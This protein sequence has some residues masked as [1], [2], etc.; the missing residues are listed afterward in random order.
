MWGSRA[1]C[2]ASSR[3]S[4]KRGQEASPHSSPLSPSQPA[5][6]SH[7]WADCSSHPDVAKHERTHTH[8]TDIGRRRKEA[9]VPEGWNVCCWKVLV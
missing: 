6:R 3:V 4:G 2:P 1:P 5:V 9:T 8:T 7:G